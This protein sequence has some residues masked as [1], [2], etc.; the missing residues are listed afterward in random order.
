M[1]KTKTKRLSTQ[2][3]LSLLLKNTKT[4]MSNKY[5]TSAPESNGKRLFLFCSSF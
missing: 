3:M 4:L 5:K 1:N 2:D